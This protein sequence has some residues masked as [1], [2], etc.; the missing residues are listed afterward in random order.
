MLT[1]SKLLFGSIAAALL[2]SMAV[3]SASARDLSLT[4]RNFRMVW[5]RLQ[6]GSTGG[7]SLDCPV[8][9]EGRFHSSTIHKTIG[10][11]IGFMTRGTVVPGSC[12]GG[13]ATINQEALPWHIRYNGFSG[14]LPRITLLFVSIIGMKSTW[15]QAGSTCV[16]QTTVA[17]PAKARLIVNEATGAGGELRLDETALI[18]LRSGF[19][20]QFVGQFFLSGTG[21]VTLL[22]NTTTISIR[23]I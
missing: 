22:G 5:S 23:L 18:P 3:G 6:I 7:V 9:L 8:T 12:T 16:T 14:T 21:R 2:L 4:N 1:R 10:A 19:F 20:C 17:N 11:L 13:T 15:T